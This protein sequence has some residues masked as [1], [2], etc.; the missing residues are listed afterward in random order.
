[1]TQS[2][3][4]TLQEVIFVWA[5]LGLLEKLTGVAV[6]GGEHLVD[7]ARCCD[8]PGISIPHYGNTAVGYLSVVCNP[9]KTKG[10]NLTRG[11]ERGEAIERE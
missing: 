4:S 6:E 11:R 8:D 7:G 9:F 2:D 5:Y 10:K 1:M 3:W